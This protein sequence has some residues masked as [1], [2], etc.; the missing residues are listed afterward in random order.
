MLI[1]QMKAHIFPVNTLTTYTQV[2][3]PSPF[4]VVVLFSSTSWSS[5]VGTV[6]VCTGNLWAASVGMNLKF[7]HGEFSQRCRSHG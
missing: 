3:N 5:S 6:K 7:N 4:N 2:A 1:A